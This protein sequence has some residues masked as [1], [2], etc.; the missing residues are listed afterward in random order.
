MIDVCQETRQLTRINFLKKSIKGSLRD[1]FL[2][3]IKGNLKGLFEVLDD[4]KIKEH[5]EM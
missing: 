5:V 4:E 1:N 2:R 3:A